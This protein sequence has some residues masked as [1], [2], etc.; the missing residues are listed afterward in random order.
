MR[1]ENHAME[2]A[3]L[4]YATG[5]CVKDGDW[6]RLD[7]ET[8]VGRVS[9]VLN[10]LAQARSRGFDVRGVLVDAPPKGLVF[11]S[12][13]YLRDAPLQFIRRSPGEALRP[14]LAV[15]L[16]VGVVAF[17][18]ALYSWFSALY[19]A[20]TTGQVMVISLGY[21]HTHRESVAWHQGWARSA[22]PVFLTAAWLLFDGSRASTARWWMSGTSAAVGLAL[23]LFSAWFTSIGAAV[24]FLSLT[25]G[26]CLAAVIDRN[27]GRGAALLFMVV[28]LLVSVG[29]AMAVR[30]L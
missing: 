12:E 8:A 19:S 26:M 28:A 13:Q 29:A 6:V 21:N 23:L 16:G 24:S 11:L 17:L 9:E 10:T 4:T 27:L 2:L 25:C 15:A 3:R 7:G 22:G 18:P 1:L 5:A 20:V 14:Q 30:S